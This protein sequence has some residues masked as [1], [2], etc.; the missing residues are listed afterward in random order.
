LWDTGLSL[1]DVDPLERGGSHG[2][3]GRRVVFDQRPPADSPDLISPR[4]ARSACRD[5]LPVRA[6]ALYLS[7]G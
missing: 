6:S 4:S 2:R 3:F 5:S 7:P 1:D